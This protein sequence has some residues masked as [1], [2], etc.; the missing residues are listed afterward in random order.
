M[1]DKNFGR[2]LRKGQ[3]ERWLGLAGSYLRNSGNEF[4]E[5]FCSFLEEGYKDSEQSEYVFKE[6]SWAT[7]KQ[8]MLKKALDS[9]IFGIPS[10]Q[11]KGFALIG[12]TDFNKL[13]FIK[14]YFEACGLSELIG[15]GTKD[16]Y[17][18][19]DCSGIK[20]YGGLV[21]SLVKNQEA[22]YIIFD[23][24]GSL[25]KHDEVLQVFK[26]L[27]EENA[28]ITLVIKNDETV[29]FKT[30]SS[31]IFLGEENTL[32][33]A[34]ERQALKEQGLDA[35]AYNHFQAFVHYIHVYD[36]EKNERYYGNNVIPVY[37]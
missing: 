31:F 18:V 20:G 9:E 29:N 35:S 27:S 24:C 3:K 8:V 26:Q 36:F 17:A 19:V 15:D 22:V 25:L 13:E 11:T 6:P 14:E 2:D 4:L 23:N 30:D 37:S 7:E 34:V 21:K 10:T 32:H 16:H 5:L 12:K 1:N 33:T 28:G